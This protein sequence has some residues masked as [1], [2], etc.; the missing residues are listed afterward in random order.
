MN[1]K[2]DVR[3]GDFGVVHFPIG[4]KETKEEARDDPKKES[5]VEKKDT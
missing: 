2:P 1:N 4:L 5:E 3:V